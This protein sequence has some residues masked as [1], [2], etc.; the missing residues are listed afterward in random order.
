MIPKSLA[1]R[2]VNMRLGWV[3]VMAVLFHGLYWMD[4]TWLF[5]FR[6]FDV[7]AWRG[8]LALLLLLPNLLVLGAYTI[9]LFFWRSVPRLRQSLAAFWFLCLS[10]LVL[11]LPIR[12]SHELRWWTNVIPIL[13]TIALSTMLASRIAVSDFMRSRACE[14]ILECSGR[15][16][17]PFFILGMC[18]GATPLSGYITVSPRVGTAYSINPQSGIFSPCL[19]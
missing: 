1:F 8:P 6:R 5:A 16:F 7:L 12:L 10:S 2:I 13:P 14:Y 15:A 19:S 3:V 9:L 18:L 11:L 4:Y 17:V